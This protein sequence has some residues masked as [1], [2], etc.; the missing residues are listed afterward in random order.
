MKKFLIPSLFTLAFCLTIYFVF[1]N[2]SESLPEHIGSADTVAGYLM[3]FSALF[4]VILGVWKK[5]DVM[6]YIKK[7]KTKP[8]FVGAGEPFE[9]PAE[10]FKAAIIPVSRKEQPEWIIRHLKP[11]Y[12]S[13]IYT[14]QS[15]DAAKSLI[16]EFSDKIEFFPDIDNA[17]DPSYMLA[18]PDKVEDAQIKAKRCMR[19]YIRKGLDLSEIFVD[20]TG[21]K[22]PMSIG[23][24]Q[25]AEQAGASSIYVVGTQEQ[26]IIKDPA[27]REHGQPI[28]ISEHNEENAS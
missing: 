9:V 11:A 5:D 3:N 6:K 19:R 16:K 13:L 24:F 25:A 27:I 26:G 14:E 15:R 8:E 7:W 1:G 28:F 22:V 12:V 18:T 21:G 4:T 20:T 10:R 2:I 17:E 23:M